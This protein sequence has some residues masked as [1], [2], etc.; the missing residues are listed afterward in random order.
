MRGNVQGCPDPQFQDTSSP[1]FSSSAII[2]YVLIMDEKVVDDRGI[3]TMLRTYY[4]IEMH[5]V[6]VMSWSIVRNPVDCR[7][8][9]AQWSCIPRAWLWLRISERHRS[10]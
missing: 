3:N 6:D 1:F 5:K 10:I 9:Y 7:I 2:Y 8:G 4:T